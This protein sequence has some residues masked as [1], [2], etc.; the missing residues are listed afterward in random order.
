MKLKKSFMTHNADGEHILIDTEGMF[1]GI[2]RSNETAAFIVEC[3]KQETT[4]EEI[5]NVLCEKYDA[6]R[7]VIALDVKKIMENLRSVG[8]LD[9]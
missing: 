6:P 2:V 9:E 7:A 4:E 3:L 1:S 8:A 5:V